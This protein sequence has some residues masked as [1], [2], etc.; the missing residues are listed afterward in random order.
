MTMNQSQSVTKQKTPQ[1]I[2]E[3]GSLDDF[4]EEIGVLLMDN[5][6]GHA[7]DDVIHLLTEAPVRVIT[8]APHT[9]QIFQVF[10]VTVFGALKRR[11]RYE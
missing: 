8:F 5:C 9:T 10:N 2:S 3:L 4:A 11:P 1:P 7:T 6:A